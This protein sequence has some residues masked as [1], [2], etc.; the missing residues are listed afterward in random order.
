MHQ[1]REMETIMMTC[2]VKTPE[3]H[4]RCRNVSTCLALASCLPLLGACANLG[5]T[6]T[7]FLE[8]YSA[9]RT[10]PGQPRDPSYRKP[11]LSEAH[12]VA[13]IVDPVVLRLADDKQKVSTASAKALCE[14][15][16]AQLRTAFAVHYAEATGPGPGVIRIRAAVTALRRAQPVLNAVT[17]AAVLLPVTAGGASSETEVIDSVTSERLVALQSFNNGGKSFL[18]GPLG[19]L[20]QYGQAR[21]ALAG[22][23]RELAALTA[24]GKA[25]PLVQATR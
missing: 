22:Q 9:L 1:S 7:G 23:A 5:T 8:D 25:T 11:T 21:R 14:D 24:G 20:S 12:Y 4:H 18:G 16:R 3:S 6:R 17:M 15:F 13:F 10:T 2:T 19:Y